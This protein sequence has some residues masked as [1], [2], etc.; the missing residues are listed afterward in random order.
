MK[1]L[2]YSIGLVVLL[3]GLTIPG[4]SSQIL[5]KVK[6]KTEDAIIKKAFGE[7][8]QK[9]EESP[10]GTSSSGTSGPSNTRGGGL[11][12][13]APD[14]QQNINDAQLAFSSKKYGDAKYAIR[15]AL[16]G[17]ELEIGKNILEGLPES[18]AGL[19]KVDSEDN[20]TSSGIGFVGLII[21][22]AYRGGDQE[23]RV[24]IGN[25]AGMLSAVNMYLASGA[26]ATSS[27]QEN[28]QQ[29][30]FKDYRAVI[31]Y[32]E[33]SGYTLSVPFGQSSILVT[34]GVN[35]SSEEEFM[36]ASLTIDIETIKKQLGEQ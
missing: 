35:F 26:Y 24:N 23:L 36:N 2:L 13:K 1:K 14:I 10:T 29:T 4:A 8:E 6:R 32:D 7:D 12:S 31:E 17:V 22:R 19:K 28:V 20:V 15:Q 33:Y 3:T 11:N 30:K 9:N 5:E 34:E 16:L 18:V 25:D 27:Q 21:N